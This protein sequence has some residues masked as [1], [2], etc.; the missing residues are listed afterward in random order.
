MLKETFSDWCPEKTKGMYHLKPDLHKKK[1]DQTKAAR[2]ERTA[3]GIKG[4]F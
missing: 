2:I 1:M 4:K 3:D